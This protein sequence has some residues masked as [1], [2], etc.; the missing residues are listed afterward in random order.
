MVV[1]PPFWRNIQRS[2][3]ED[4]KQHFEV[5]LAQK[6][7]LVWTLSEAPS[8]LNFPVL[9]SSRAPLKLSSVTVVVENLRAGHQRGGGPLVKLL[10][11]GGDGATAFC[12]LAKSYHCHCFL[13]LC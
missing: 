1:G 9:F 6:R 3:E 10:G 4:P 13:Y 2:A 5:D 12:I 7:K 11:E 8:D